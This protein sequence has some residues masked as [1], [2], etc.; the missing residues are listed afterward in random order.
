MLPRAPPSLP[1]TRT[2]AAAVGVAGVTRPRILFPRTRW[3][4]QGSAGHF[5][6]AD[7]CRYHLCTVVGPWLV[8]TIG[9]YFPRNDETQQTVGLDRMFETMVFRVEPCDRA[10]CREFHQTSGEELDFAAANTRAEAQR[11]H[12]RLCDA[13]SRKAPK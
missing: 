10:D 6:A 8:S 13:W 5:C 12:E 7:R 9:E 4:W 11:E 1:A 2:A 3:K